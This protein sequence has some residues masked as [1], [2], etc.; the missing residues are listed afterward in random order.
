MGSRLRFSSGAAKLIVAKLAVA[1]GWK[2]KGAQKRIPCSG[3]FSKHRNPRR[4]NSYGSQPHIWSV[5][6]LKGQC[7]LQ[8]FRALSFR[9]WGFVTMLFGLPV[10]C[11]TTHQIEFS[12]LTLGQSR[13]GRSILGFRACTGEHQVFRHLLLSPSSPSHP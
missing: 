5:T 8:D 6:V 10:S 1:Q 9:V 4:S 3:S 2:E 13:R 12:A 11:R 7:V